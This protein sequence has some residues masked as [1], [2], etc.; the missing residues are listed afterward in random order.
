MITG[1]KSIL[2]LRTLLPLAFL[3]TLLSIIGCVPGTTVPRGWSGG[4]IADGTLFIGSMDGKIV[5]MNSSDG[6]LIWEAPLEATAPP[7]GG[8]GCAAPPTSVAIDRKS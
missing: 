2:R 4:T 8:F 3:L 7:S 5:A 1:L 6:K